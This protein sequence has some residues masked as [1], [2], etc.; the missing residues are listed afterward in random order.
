MRLK[1]S[2]IH[3]EIQK[4]LANLEDFIND[5]W[6]EYSDQYQLLKD[7]IVLNPY[8]GLIAAGTVDIIEIDDDDDDCIFVGYPDF[9]ERES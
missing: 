2:R 5:V 6:L 3:E 1:C 7:A 4:S 9:P 8:K